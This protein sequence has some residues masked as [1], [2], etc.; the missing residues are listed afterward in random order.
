MKKKDIYTKLNDVKMDINKID[1]LKEMF[2]QVLDETKAIT[3][4]DKLNPNTIKDPGLF[5][6]LTGKYQKAKDS[7]IKMETVKLKI[8]KINKIKK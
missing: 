7:K 1:K 6:I 8:I 4:L 5:G 2:G 3:T